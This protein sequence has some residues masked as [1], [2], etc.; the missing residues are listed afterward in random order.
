MSS[1][2]KPISSEEEYF[3]REDAEKL[4]RA[5]AKRAEDLAQAEQVRLK[6]LHYMH[7]PKC[8]MELSTLEMRGL[9]IERCFHCNGT[10]LDEGELEQ[11]AGKEGGFVTRLVS[12]FKEPGS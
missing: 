4:R 2:K 10:W 8:G 1:V 9:Q 6:E 11:L 7:C 12:F 3:A 5:A